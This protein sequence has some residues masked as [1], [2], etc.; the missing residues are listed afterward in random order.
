M[1]TM[2]ITMAIM[3][4]ANHPEIIPIRIIETIISVLYTMLILVIA[5]TTSVLLCLYI[6][7][8][9]AFCYLLAWSTKQT[10]CC[11]Y[12]GCLKN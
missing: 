6:I 3:Q 5:H 8:Y 1:T 11:K 12:I 10:D 4:K 2:M 7:L 9:R